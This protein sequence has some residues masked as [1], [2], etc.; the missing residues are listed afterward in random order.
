MAISILKRI[1]NTAANPENKEATPNGKP[2]EMKKE[3]PV[4]EA[5]DD[6][7]EDE[8]EENAN[9]SVDPKK[10]K[11]KKN[12]KKKKK[13][14]K[15]QTDPPSI[16]I[17]ELFPNAIYPVGELLEHPISLTG[18]VGPLVVVLESDQFKS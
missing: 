15:Q 6:G 14:S 8:E 4:E 5:A 12:K 3:Q 16:P 2:E 11:K 13:T 9:E 10:P 18:L 1:Q 17:K 7:E